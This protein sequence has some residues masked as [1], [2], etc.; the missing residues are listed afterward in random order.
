MADAG[1][2]REAVVTSPLVSPVTL[3]RVAIIAAVLVGWEALAQSE[4]LYRDVVPSLFAIG[5]AIWSLL[6]DPQYYF[7]LGVTAG[8]VLAA[9][10]IG[11]IS[12]VVVG[13]VLGANKFLSRAYEPYL[14][15]LGPTPKII[16]FPIMIM[17]FGVGP[18][19]KV[20]LGVL[21]CFFPIAL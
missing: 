16:F 7:H 9:L 15:Y 14:Y 19:S 20:A 18:P 17:W 5:K 3:V 11:G 1:R 12:A 2:L 6:S 4:L 10:A 13:L 21:S 8:E